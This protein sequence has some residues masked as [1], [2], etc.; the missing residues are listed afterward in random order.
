MKLY[1]YLNDYIEKKELNEKLELVSERIN[2]WHEQF[3]DNPTKH[4]QNASPEISSLDDDRASNSRSFS[5]DS[6]LNS[7]G[8]RGK[9]K[10]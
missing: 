5:R 1:K 8:D 6:R 10:G 2:E 4:Q 3:F 9:A 7:L